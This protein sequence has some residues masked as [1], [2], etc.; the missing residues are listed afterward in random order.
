[1]A[2]QT[3]TGFRDFLPADCAQRNYIFT[4]WREVAARHGFVEYEGP[5]LES[6]DLYRKKS[7]QE[8]TDQLFCFTTKGG[9][10]VSMRPETTP[11]L[12]RLAAAKQRD[13]AKPMKWFQIGTCY[14]YERKQRGRLREFYQFNVDILGEDSPAAD[15]ELIA[16]AIE[17][18]RV[19]GL[20]QGEFAIR[21][22]DR[23]LWADFS[24]AQGLNADQAAEFL[25]IIDKMERTPEEVTDGKLKALGVTLAQV[26]E[27]IASVDENHAVFTPLRENLQARG[28]WSYVK[29]DPGIVRGLAYYTGTVFEAFDLKHGLRAVAGGGRYD[30]LVSLLSD[31]AVNL[32]ACGFAMGD[33]VLGELIKATA[34]AQ[35]RM[36]DW[37]A[38]ASSVEV[39]VVVADEAKRSDALGMVQT[40]RSAG[41]R[42]DYA[43]TPQKVGKQFQAAD[44]AK[45][46]FSVV[47][48]T[49]FPTV[50][51][52]NMRTRD[53]MECPANGIIA[54][55]Q[56]LQTATEYRPLLA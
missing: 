33:V 49:E 55:L 27:F 42:T 28:L 30:N 3:L 32:P 19:F 45:A 51:I 21:L 26:K 4:R 50:T 7:G 37:V 13:F 8:I 20:Q 24:S 54:K 9:E 15:A 41:L 47:I 31:G 10:E 6:T 43:Y 22:S 17:S 14:R 44:A 53:K 18:L 40:L 23:R 25:G 5:T 16:C 34:D 56:E 1:M 38:H 12:A 46:R 39:Y 52:Q 35:Q 36:A 2:F 11:T 48:G 29:I